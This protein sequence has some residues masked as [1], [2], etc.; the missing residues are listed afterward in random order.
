MDP[1]PH[2][3]QKA[4]ALSL[5]YTLAPIMRSYVMYLSKAYTSKSNLMVVILFNSISAWSQIL[6]H[7]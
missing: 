5:S 1:G 6:T 2:K 7:N 4:F 3:Y